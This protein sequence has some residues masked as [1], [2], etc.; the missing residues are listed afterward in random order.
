MR[1]E[2]LYEVVREL[3]QG[4]CGRVLLV[5]NRKTGSQHAA[6]VLMNPNDAHALRLFR[7]EVR[8]LSFFQRFA[9]WSEIEAAYLKATPPFFVM[10]YSEDGSITRWAGKLDRTYMRPRERVDSASLLRGCNRPQRCHVHDVSVG[11]GWR[12]QSITGHGG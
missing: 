3:G 11:D 7:R 12:A 5:R 6:K 10:P 8:L 4:G 9:E 1:L 2:D